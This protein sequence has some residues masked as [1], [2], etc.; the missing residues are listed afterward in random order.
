MPKLKVEAPVQPDPNASYIVYKKLE[1]VD[2][3]I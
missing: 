1:K 3:P 2:Q